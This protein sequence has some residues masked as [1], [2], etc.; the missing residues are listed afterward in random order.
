MMLGQTTSGQGEKI[1][2][3]LQGDPLQYRD[4]L[5]SLALERLQTLS[6]ALGGRA[7]EALGRPWGALMAVLWSWKAP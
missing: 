7:W 5:A 1:S 6:V 3:S 2:I 4:A